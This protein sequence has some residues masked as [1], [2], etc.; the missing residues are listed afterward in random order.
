LTKIILRKGKR[1]H[2]DAEVNLKEGLTGR[3]KQ[4]LI[5]CLKNQYR[6][7]IIINEN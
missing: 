1:G 4:N 3:E 5:A 2:K 7:V 6:K